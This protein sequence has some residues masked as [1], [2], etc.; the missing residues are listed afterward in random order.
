MPSRRAASFQWRAA[1]VPATLAIP[2]D[3]NG[4]WWF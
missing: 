2:V 4:T 3:G 1:G